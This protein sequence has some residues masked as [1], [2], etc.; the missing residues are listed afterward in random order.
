VTDGGGGFAGG[1]GDGAGGGASVGGGALGT[2]GE[3]T[4]LVRGGLAI[5]GGRS[6][7]FGPTFDAI[8]EGNVAALAIAGRGGGAWS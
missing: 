8:G 2:G 7:M 4:T 3:L 1:G 6:A 5:G